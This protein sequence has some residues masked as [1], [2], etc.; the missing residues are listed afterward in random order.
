MGMESEVQSHIGGHITLFFTVEKEGRL[1]RNQG[2]RGVGLNIDHGVIASVKQV[3][4][5]GQISDSTITIIDHEGELLVDSEK[6][7]R[8]L[9][10]ELVYARLLK[11]SYT[12]NIEITLQLPTSQGMGMSAAGLIALATAFRE[13][14][15]EGNLDQYYRICHRI[16]RLRGSGL[17]DALGIY[18][19]GVEI[20]LQPGAPGASGRSLGFPC[21]QPVIVVW[22]PG[23]KR[24]TSSYIDNSEWQLKITQAGHR[25]LNKLKTGPWNH[26]RWSDILIQSNNFSRESE[27]IDESE[28]KQLLNLVRKVVKDLELQ[29]HL[30]IRLCMLGVSVVILPRKLNRQI[31]KQELDQLYNSLIQLNL[32][33]IITSIAS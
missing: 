8:Q 27:L 2:S 31:S 7:Y 17:G 30:S 32:G 16:E 13:L 24:H 22:Q 21:R 5:D 9:I 1:L 12:Y 6:Q 3:S 10:D 33:S 28:R 26:S 29:T 23:E 19:G 20:R 15:G 4:S 14:T 11:E 25:A 18:A